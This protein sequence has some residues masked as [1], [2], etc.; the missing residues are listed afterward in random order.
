MF[1]NKHKICLKRI[2][3]KMA[4]NDSNGFVNY[5]ERELDK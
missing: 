3:R 1:F 5:A 4:R 2:Q